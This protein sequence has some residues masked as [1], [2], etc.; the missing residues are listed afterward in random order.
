MSA[1]VPSGALPRCALHPD[2]LAGATCQRC[3][4]F[5]CTEC[6]TWVM[7][8]MY[9]PA[10]AVRPEVNY[11]EAFRLKLWGRRDASAWLVV[12]VTVVLVGLAL[13]ALMAGDV[14]TT[15]ACLGSSGVG[16]AFF[17]GMRWARMGLLAV[18]LL[19]MLL[20]AQSL[21]APA[22]LFFIPLMVAVNVFRDTRSRLFFRLDVPE[23][24][25]RQLWDLRV[26]NPLARHALS[27]SVGS[28]F[29]PVFAPLLSYFGVWSALTFV[30][31]GLSML[32][33]ILGLVALRRVDP[34]ARPP[35]GR[36]WEALGAVCLALVALALWG[37][38]HR[39]RMV[40][41]LGGAVD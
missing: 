1:E 8:R 27:L 32:A 28:L 2:A 9:C 19:A 38:L 5:V 10:C 17:L 24:E 37:V 4:S 11:L 18:P 39:T 26:N 25:L 16:V 6:T 7:G 30:F 40:E 29:L 33:L 35:I 22:L 14:G 13:V 15:L 23:R 34:E 12:G 3:G 20:T 41:L 31:A 21:G 36:R